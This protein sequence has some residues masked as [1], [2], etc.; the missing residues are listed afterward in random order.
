VASQRLP[1]T[2]VLHEPPVLSVEVV[3]DVLSALVA[4]LT[5]VEDVF[6]VTELETPVEL[7]ASTVLPRASEIDAPAAHAP[8]A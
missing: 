3:L 6:E 4:L 1:F 5:T 8:D 2:D 7:P